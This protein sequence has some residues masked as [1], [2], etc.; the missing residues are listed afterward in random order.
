MSPAVRMRSDTRSF[1]KGKTRKK[2]RLK[3]MM[4]PYEKLKSL[5][6]AAAFLKPEF[7]FELLDQHAIA[8]TDNE[9]ARQLNDART[10]LFQSIHR[11]SK[12]AA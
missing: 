2:Y 7:T 4:T 10:K 3:D 1:E 12:H 9:A 6:N 11:R 5:P 8:I